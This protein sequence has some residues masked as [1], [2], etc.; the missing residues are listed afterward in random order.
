MAGSDRAFISVAALNQ[1]V[2][3]A[4]KSEPG[5]VWLRVEV[6]KLDIPSSGHWYFTLKDANTDTR[7]LGAMLIPNQLHL[8]FTPQVGDILE[9]HGQVEV[10]GVSSKYQINISTMRKIEPISPVP[11]PS[12]PHLPLPP[13][14]PKNHSA[15]KVMLL[16]GGVVFVLLLLWALL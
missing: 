16:I 2:S 8:G 14:L 9:L 10:F 6:L 3:A 15:K 4:L 11:H 5:G 1:R 13:P 12:S 7:I